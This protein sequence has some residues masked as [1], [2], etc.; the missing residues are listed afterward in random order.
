MNKL[1]P[2]LLFTFIL[3]IAIRCDKGESGEK[4]IATRV[5]VQ[6]RDNALYI[7]A[8]ELLDSADERAIDLSD[9]KD[10]KNASGKKNFA[11]DSK[12]GQ[13]FFCEEDVSASEV[14]LKITYRRNT[15]LKDTLTEPF[16]FSLQNHKNSLSED[17]TIMPHHIKVRFSGCQM[18]IELPSFLRNGQKKYQ[19]SINGKASNDYRDRK[20]QWDIKDRAGKMVDVWVAIEGQD[21]IGSKMNKQSKIPF[22]DMPEHDIEE[23]RT[24]LAKHASD[25]GD[26][27]EDLEALL[28]IKDIIRNSFAGTNPLIVV[29]GNPIEE[30][31]VWE[32]R[33]YNQHLDHN[34]T[35]KLIGRPEILEEAN[36]KRWKLV[37]SKK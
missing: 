6:T 27:P 5:E 19:V 26:N 34:T 7:K 11:W 2:Y 24:A 4:N 22:C 13:L 35:Y 3:F 21:T 16:L 33:F 23:L 15:H 18:I 37:Y 9:I 1:K 25:F 30:I 17:C 8:F 36:S 12:N 20:L 10:I 29:D 31:T 32:N 14:R 28:A